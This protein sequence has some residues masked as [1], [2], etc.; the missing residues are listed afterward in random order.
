[1]SYLKNLQVKSWKISTVLT[2]YPARQQVERV[3][4]MWDQGRPKGWRGPWAASEWE[5]ARGSRW[6]DGTLRRGEWAAPA[7][8]GVGGAGEKSEWRGDGDIARWAEMPR[9][10]LEGGWKRVRVGTLDPPIKGTWRRRNQ[11]EKG[12]SVQRGQ[13]DGWA[14]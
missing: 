6:H 5:L 7:E 11:R 9:G 10:G 2:T 14:G 3:P 12:W 13:R 1:M 8:P 4:G